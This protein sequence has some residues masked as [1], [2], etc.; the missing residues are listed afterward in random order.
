MENTQENSN[1]FRHKY[2]AHPL[3]RNKIELRV[4]PIHGYGIFA[5]KKILPGETIEE[6]P[7]ILLRKDQPLFIL[8]NLAFKWN[9]DFHILALGYGSFYNHATNNNA[10]YY[11]DDDHQLL[12]FKASKIIYPGEEI[13]TNYGEDWFQIRGIEIKEPSTKINR[14]RRIIRLVILATIFVTC[15]V[16]FSSGWFK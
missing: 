14:R 15:F 3:I 10:K 9:D 12:V 2:K 11:R 6:C 8:N 5:K 1:D 4:S 13:C 7:L 16:V